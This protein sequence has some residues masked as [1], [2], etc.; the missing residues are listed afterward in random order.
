MHH[1]QPKNPLHGVTLEAVV[2]RLAEHFGWEELGERI[3]INCFLINPS[4]RSS[5]TYLRRTQWVRDEVEALYIAT[6]C[7]PPGDG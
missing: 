7:T 6:F 2:T 3:P 1:H 4:V 5:L